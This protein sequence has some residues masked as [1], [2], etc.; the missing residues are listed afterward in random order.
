MQQPA[1]FQGRFLDR[2]AVL[3]IEYNQRIWCDL[4]SL[5]VAY[6]PRS[7]GIHQHRLAL[8]VRQRQPQHR[9]ASKW[10]REPYS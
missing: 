1:D 4:I 5:N 3:S 8:R 6:R 9:V 7:L 10:T 2:L